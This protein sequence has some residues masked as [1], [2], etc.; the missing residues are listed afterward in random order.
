M[1]FGDRLKFL[2][3]KN[4]WTQAK[5]A[6]EA[7]TTIRVISYYENSKDNSMPNQELLLKFAKAFNML[8]PD[9]L[10]FNK[11]ELAYKGS[12]TVLPQD[13]APSKN[14][15]KITIDEIIET[16]GNYI[17]L[18]AEK[19]PDDW[20]AAGIAE[21]MKNDRFSL[22]GLGDIEKFRYFK[23]SNLVEFLERTEIPFREHALYSAIVD[24]IKNDCRVDTDE[25]EEDDGIDEF[26]IYKIFE[27]VKGYI[28][29]E[30]LN[31]KKELKKKKDEN[32]KLTPEEVLEKTREVANA[33][34][35]A[36]EWESYTPPYGDKPAERKTIKRK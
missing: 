18:Y 30:F 1:N 9:L 20:K 35:E 26:H 36:K 17:A 32:D 19:N 25:T 13:G 24:Y 31:I 3:K 21:E 34:K 10:S 4:K 29:F 28:A 11:E 23:Q 6:E 8:L 5:L 15:E 27:K 22:S 33:M 12:I 2:R 7:G 16:L 14:D